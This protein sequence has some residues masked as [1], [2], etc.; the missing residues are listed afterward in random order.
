VAGQLSRKI[1]LVVKALSGKMVQTDTSTH[2]HPNRGQKGRAVQAPL[3]MV[4]IYDLHIYT[5]LLQAPQPRQT[6]E[7]KDSILKLPTKE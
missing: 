1:I 5:T 3:G 4:L 6:T 7:K 2:R